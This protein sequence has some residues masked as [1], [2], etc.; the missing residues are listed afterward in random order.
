MV[1]TT[2]GTT[3]TETSLAQGNDTFQG[4]HERCK[5]DWPTNSGRA[6]SFGNNDGTSCRHRP[7]NSLIRIEIYDVLKHNVEYFKQAK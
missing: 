2:P 1:C 7:E 4:S 3:S 5:I 6:S